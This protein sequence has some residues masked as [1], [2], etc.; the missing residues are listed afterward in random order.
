MQHR[1]SIVRG[2]SF[3]FRRHGT[4]GPSADRTGK[5]CS[6]GATGADRMDHILRTARV[7]GNE[8]VTTDV[9]IDKG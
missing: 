3:T 1:S 4:L 6:A 9:G 8:G 2:Q 7:V 5:L